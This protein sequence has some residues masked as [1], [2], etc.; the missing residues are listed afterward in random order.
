MRVLLCLILFLMGAI[1]IVGLMQLLVWGATALVC[2]I[3]DAVDMCKKCFR[4]S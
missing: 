4:G 3:S 2:L 1:L